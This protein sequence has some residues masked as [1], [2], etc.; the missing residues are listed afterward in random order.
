MAD[1]LVCVEIGYFFRLQWLIEDD[2]YDTGAIL[3]ENYP[4]NVSTAKKNL[5]K[6]NISTEEKI[7]CIALI[8]AE[9][10]KGMMKD[11][12]GYYWET[13]KEAREALK[14]IKASIKNFKEDKTNWPDWTKKALLNNWKPPKNW[15]PSY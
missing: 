15:K 14:Y 12:D 13:K 7:D 1:K 11:S 4:K 3:G 2:D 10:T 9:E 6:E 8:A 5:E